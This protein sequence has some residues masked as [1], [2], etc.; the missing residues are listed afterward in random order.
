MKQLEKKFNKKYDYS[1]AIYRIFKSVE[2]QNNWFIASDKPLLSE[3]MD[4]EIIHEKH[5]GIKADFGFGKLKNT[6]RIDTKL[7][8]ED[9]RKY[10]SDKNLLKNESFKYKNL[11]IENNTVEYNNIKASKIVFC[12]GFWI[13]TKSIF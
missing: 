12:E 11:K 7:L 1:V 4:P 10:L 3:Y 8:L 13:K 5:S 2:E 9:F 6:G